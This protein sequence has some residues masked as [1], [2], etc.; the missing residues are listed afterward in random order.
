M[1]EHPNIA[2]LKKDMEESKKRES[3]I[4]NLDQNMKIVHKD[5][6]ITEMKMR[7]FGEFGD[8]GDKGFCRFARLTLN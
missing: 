2:L 7:E 5:I 3:D 4:V 8:F 1:A 6:E